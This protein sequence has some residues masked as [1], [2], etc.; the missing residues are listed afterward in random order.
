MGGKKIQTSLFSL[1]CSNIAILS[2]PLS[3]KWKLNLLW[4]VTCRD[5]LV[6]NPTLFHSGPNIVLQFTSNYTYPS[7]IPPGWMP[8]LISFPLSSTSTTTPW[9]LLRHNCRLYILVPIDLEGA[10]IYVL[11]GLMR[12][13]FVCIHITCIYRNGLGLSISSGLGQLIFE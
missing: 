8:F 1:R 3:E 7:S 4:V 12:M 9:D 10:V 6:T 5:L 13:L 2:H 11:V